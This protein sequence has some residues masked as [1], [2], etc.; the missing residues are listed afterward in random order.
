MLQIILI[1]IIN[2]YISLEVDLCAALVALGVV[3]LFSPGCRLHLVDRTLLQVA[4][5]EEAKGE[6]ETGGK[7]EASVEGHDN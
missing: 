2:L 6:A 1:M 5:K 4:E 3:H 7:E